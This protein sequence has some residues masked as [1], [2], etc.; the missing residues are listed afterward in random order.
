MRYALI[1]AALLMLAACE[2]IGG[3][4][5]IVKGNANT[6]VRDEVGQRVAAALARFDSTPTVTD[7]DIQAVYGMIRE[8]ALAGELQAALVLLK[9]AERQ[10]AAEEEEGAEE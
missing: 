10:R 7:A 9:V 5:T 1:G 2:F 6:V 8:Q 3:G 4:D